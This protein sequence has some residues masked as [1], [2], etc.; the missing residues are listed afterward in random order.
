M[1]LVSYIKRESVFHSLGPRTK[2]I[3]STVLILLSF[4][5]NHP[6]FLSILFLLVV[7]LSFVA[8]I[9]R[10]FLN[11]IKI[12]ASMIVLAFI[13]WA[14]FW[15]W[16]L[17]VHSSDSQTIF[18]VGPISLD[19]FG[20]LYGSG[21]VFRVLIM[22]G[23][24]LLFFMTTSLSELTLGLV[25]LK[26]P[27]ALAFTFGLSAKLIPYLTKEFSTIR[28]AQMARG[29]ELDKGNIFKRI[30]AYIPVI[31]PLMLRSLEF[32]EYMSIAMETK[33]FNIRR[34]RTFYKTLTLK[35]LDFFV[36]VA[37]ILALIFGIV[38]RFYGIGVIR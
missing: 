6:F 13:L 34:K 23:V 38:L 7:I 25:K 16:S 24:P 28:E 3:L 18:R 20:L 21:M 32:S 10:E 15:R 35:K 9:Q 14:F 27:F 17:L 1:K 22:I 4:I 19:K 31:I 11:R 2:L 8:K 33:G 12:L 29:L 5:F 36:I 37:S 26:F 30:R